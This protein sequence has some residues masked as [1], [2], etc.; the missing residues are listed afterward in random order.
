MLLSLLAHGAALTWMLP[1]LPRPRSIP[2]SSPAERVIYADLPPLAPAR[3]APPPAE[4]SA[5][6]S[7]HPG[8][9]SSVAESKSA[10]VLGTEN[11]SVATPWD[12]GS[13]S[14]EA[15][16]PGSGG[17]PAGQLRAGFADA[18][19]Y[20]QP[21]NLASDAGLSPAQQLAIRAEGRIGAFN[22]SIAAEEV[23]KAE[24]RTVQVGRYR[25]PLF[26]SA[27]AYVSP[28]WRQIR[29]QEAERERRRVF[30]ERVRAT[31]ERKEWERAQVRQP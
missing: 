18:R 25:V 16:L 1:E 4:G 31:R 27:D 6:R 9:R 3:T 28:E 21:Y 10:A 30:A 14:G 26:G 2:L 23:R 22:D 17:S 12:T 5:A 8:A 24:A 15:P 13:A 20:V 29:D 19:L 11:L 7:R